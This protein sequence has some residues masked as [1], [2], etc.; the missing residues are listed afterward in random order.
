MR[1]ALGMSGDQGYNPYVKAQAIAWFDKDNPN[2]NFICTTVGLSP[3]YVIKLLKKFGTEKKNFVRSFKIN[4]T[5][6][7]ELYVM[8]LEDYQSTSRFIIYEESDGTFT[9]VIK[10]N[11]F[12]DKKTAKAFIDLIANE[13]GYE[14]NE[15]IDT[16]KTIH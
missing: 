10:I 7:I 12:T 2:F 15:I 3:A 1:D 6:W 9:V 16:D 4:P 5:N 8:K 11:P 13:H 14:T